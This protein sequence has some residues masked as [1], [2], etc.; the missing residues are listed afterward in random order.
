MSACCNNQPQTPAHEDKSTELPELHKMA[1]EEDLERLLVDE[2]DDFTGCVGTCP[3]CE[4]EDNSPRPGAQNAINTIRP[5]KFPDENGS[6]V[7]DDDSRDLAHEALVGGMPEI[8]EFALQQAGIKDGHKGFTA[9]FASFRFPGA[10]FCLNKIPE[11]DKSD[12][13]K[14]FTVG[15]FYELFG[16]VGWLCPNLLKYFDAPPD[17]IWVQVA[18]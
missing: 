15:N 4:H 12:E 9:N 3:A 6:W 17:Q 18:P 13:M 16:Q 11:E 14:E 1:T 5:Y 10:Q 7:F 8:I 2:P